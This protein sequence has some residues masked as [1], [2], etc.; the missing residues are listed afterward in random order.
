MN[1]ED[2]RYLRQMHKLFKEGGLIQEPELCQVCGGDGSLYEVIAR[3]D[4]RMDQ[5]YPDQH[6]AGQCST[7]MGTGLAWEQ[8]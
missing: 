1:D 2:R 4:E 7:C 3:Y 5:F 8:E 6:Y